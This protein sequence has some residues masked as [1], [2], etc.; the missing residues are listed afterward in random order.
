MAQIV[1]SG[2]TDASTCTGPYRVEMVG[3]ST[4]VH[5]GAAGTAEA[6]VV[7]GAT[8]DTG[9]TVAAGAAATVAAGA[10]V[11]AGAAVAAGMFDA[12]VEITV[13]APTAPVAVPTPSLAEAPTVLLGRSSAVSSSPLAPVST[14]AGSARRARLGLGEDEGFIGLPP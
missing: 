11:A 3:P 2:A 4:I 9:A 5:A 12:G 7:A 14:R 8:G 6:T 1:P 13:G 10:F